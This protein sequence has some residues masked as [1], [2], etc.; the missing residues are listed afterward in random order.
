MCAIVFDWIQRCI[1]I[2]AA[3]GV[4]APL[5]ATAQVI[6]YHQ[7]LYSPEASVRSR[8]GSNGIDANYLV[9]QLDAWN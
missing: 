6:D 1:V 5:H 8:L 2:I 7:H 9:A 4:L 3:S